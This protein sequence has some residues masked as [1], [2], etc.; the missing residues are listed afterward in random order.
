VVLGLGGEELRCHGVG[1][2][3]LLRY[4][5][6]RMLMLTISTQMGKMNCNHGV[7]RLAN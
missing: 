1:L 5:R 6:T 2:G 4:A 7:A 3:F